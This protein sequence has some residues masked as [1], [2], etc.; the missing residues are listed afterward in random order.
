MKL[1]CTSSSSD[2]DVSHIEFDYYNLYPKHQ[3]EQC[4]QWGDNLDNFGTIRWVYQKHNNIYIH[5]LIS[6][7]NQR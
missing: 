5:Q 4:E 3:N 7:D 2:S 6:L 1:I